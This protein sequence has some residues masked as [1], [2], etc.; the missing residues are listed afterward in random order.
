MKSKLFDKN[1]PKFIALEARM[2]SHKTILKSMGYRPISK[3]RKV[4]AK[5]VAYHLFVVRLDKKHP[6]FFNY[7]MSIQ[8]KL[9]TQSRVVMNDALEGDFFHSL[10]TAEYETRIMENV[11]G[12]QPMNFTTGAEHYTDIL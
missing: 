5:P 11:I 8:N 7:F 12:S 4:W 9:T 3:D 2:P 1:R 10:L 6:V